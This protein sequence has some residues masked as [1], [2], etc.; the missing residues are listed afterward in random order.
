M[1]NQTTKSEQLRDNVIK[2]MIRYEDRLRAAGMQVEADQLHK[3]IAEYLLGIFSVMFTGAFSSGKSTTLNALMRQNLLTTSI[4]P[5]TPVITKITNGEDSDYAVIKYRDPEREDEIIPRSEFAEKYRLEFQNEGKFIEVSY[6]QLTRRLKNATVVFVDSPGLGNNTTDD[7]AANEFAKN[8]DAVVFMMHATQAMDDKARNYVESHFRC[9]HLK[10]VFIV[11][12]WYNEVQEKDEESFH[13]K[14]KHDLYDVFTNEDGSFNQ[15]LYE[16]RVFCVDSLTSFCARTGIEKGQRKGVRWISHPVPPEEDQY[17][18]IPEFEKALYE[19]LE[20]DDRDIHIYQGYMPR[21]A[22]MFGAASSHISEVLEQSRQGLEE[23]RKRR[24]QQEAGIREITHYLEDMN[25]AIET[26]VNEILVNVQSAYQSFSTSAF[27]HW[28]EYFSG[29]EISFGLGDEFKIFGLKVK[30]R[31]QDIFQPEKADEL[32]RDQEFQ[33][34]MAPI[35]SQVEEYLKGETGKMVD[36][37]KVNCEPVIQRLAVRLQGDA[38]CIRDVRLDGFNFDQMVAD[39]I[40][41]GNRGAET[42]AKKLH[43]AH[44]GKTDPISGDMSIA[45]ALISGVLLFNFDDMIADSMGGKKSWGEFLKDSLLK[46]VGDVILAIVI[47]SIFPPAWIYYAA[48]A[49]WGIL[50]MKKKAE[51]IGT[52]ILLGMKDATRQSIDDARED[53]AVKIEASFEK[54]LTWGCNE[55]INTIELALRQKQK[56]LEELIG[57][58]EAGEFDADKLKTE[59]LAAQEELVSSFN[60]L[61]ALVGKGSYTK[62]EILNYATETVSVQ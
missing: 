6:V 30:N 49:V 44:G 52:Q 4:N 7:N 1:E 16:K 19:F 39:I 34:L 59:L 45:Q 53:V 12:N 18:G 51:G 43:D 38:Q 8:A 21:M 57:R 15:E 33:K 11:V 2:E 24:D 14:L 5:E 17:T 22:G 50:T 61:A 28:D 46:E 58:I 62:E 42:A 13:E 3:K 25:H 48:R 37:V 27:N 41:A 40:A 20:A 54:E 23:L 29:K 9:R 56:Q 32:A 36:K 35:T 60:A 47:G 26:A 55:I 31:F 10:N